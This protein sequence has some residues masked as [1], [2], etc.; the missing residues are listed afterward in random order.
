MASDDRHAVESRGIAQTGQDR[1]G[2]VGVPAPDRIDHGDRTPT[3]G[4]DVAEVHH[5]PAVP[6]EIGVGG[7]EGLD[8]ALDR[9]QQVPVAVGE[10]RAVVA[11]R[12]GVG[13]LAKPET[14]DHGVDVALV[15][16][17]ASL[18]DLARQRRK[19]EGGRHQAARASLITPSSGSCRGG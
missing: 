1:V 15:G 13:A 2:R 16:D 17:A 12:N 11:D 18:A 7:H 6:G 5:D 8:E 9:Q 19:V 4:G 14:G 3:H 10:R